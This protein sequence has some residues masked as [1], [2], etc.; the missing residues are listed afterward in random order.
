MVAWIGIG[1]ADMAGLAI[2][3]SRRCV[4]CGQEIM[5]SDGYNSLRWA[6]DVRITQSQTLKVHRDCFF[7][8]DAVNQG[9][10]ANR[11]KELKDAP[12]E[13]GAGGILK[14]IE[15]LGER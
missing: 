12:V 10:E 13:I 14:M 7:D 6:V 1:K 4:W 5:M 9:W 8:F 11:F 2:P 15:D 3:P